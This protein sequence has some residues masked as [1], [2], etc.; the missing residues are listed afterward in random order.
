MIQTQ[1]GMAEL[2]NIL[3]FLFSMKFYL[4]LFQP[5]PCTT[6]GSFQ[7][8]FDIPARIYKSDPWFESCRVGEEQ[9]LVCWPSEGVRPGATSTTSAIQQV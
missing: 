5:D 2:E 9:L 1:T 4:N 3:N 7:V 6:R 8:Y